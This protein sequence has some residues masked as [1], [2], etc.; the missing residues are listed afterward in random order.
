MGPAG[1]KNV[2]WSCSDKWAML[3]RVWSKYLKKSLQKKELV[4]VTHFGFLFS[5]SSFL[6]VGG[7]Q[8]HQVCFCDDIDRCNRAGRDL[9]STLMLLLLSISVYMLL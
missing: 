6:Q 7:A 8:D 1:A 5:S 2:G 4:S 9:A 3:H